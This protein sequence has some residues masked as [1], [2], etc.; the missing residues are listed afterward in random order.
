MSGIIVF[1]IETTNLKANFGHILCFGYKELGSK[2][3]KFLVYLITHQHLRKT[4]PMTTCYAKIYLRYYL[5]QTL[6]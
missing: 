6:G 2:E 1:D 5:M 4:Q 3:L